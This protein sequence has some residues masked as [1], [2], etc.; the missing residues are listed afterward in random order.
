[1]ALLIQTSIV[2][3]QSCNNHIVKTAPDTRYQLLNNGTEVKDLTTSLIWQR[4]T[5][6]S[7]LSAG[8]CVRIGATVSNTYTWQ[9]A[10][11]AAKSAGSNWRLPNI[12]ELQSLVE[13]ACIAP[14]INVTFFPAT[15]TN[16]YWS[17]SPES[18]T[19]NKA[20]F[21][22]FYDGN[23]NVYAGDTYN[24]FYVRLVRDEL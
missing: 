2:Y 9:G 1:M 18:T 23:T 4:C 13:E 8:N 24:Q 3:A 19:N 12:Q 6:G 7:K 14:S 10:L 15:I 5:L 16:R 11:K 21:V 17:S 22:P 20:W